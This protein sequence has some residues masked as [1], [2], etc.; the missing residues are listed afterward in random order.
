MSPELVAALRIEVMPNES[1]A[2]ALDSAAG[3]CIGVVSDVAGNWSVVHVGS[4]A[5]ER[6]SSPATSDEPI[7]IVVDRGEL[8]KWLA[9]TCPSR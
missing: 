7:R 6:E 2:G 3:I 5:P 8:Q 4:S 1:A 9:V